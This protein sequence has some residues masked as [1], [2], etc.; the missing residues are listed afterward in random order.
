MK[1]NWFATWFDSNYYH[2]LYQHR[3]DAEA[4]FFIDNLIQYLDLPSQAEVLDLACGKG[5]HS[6]YL[7]QKNLVVQGV[8]LSPESI[9][10]AKQ[11]E[12]ANLSFQTHDMRQAIDFGKFDAIL[13]LFTSFGYFDTEEEHLQTLH[14]MKNGRKKQDDII[15]IDFFNAY[16]VIQNLVLE[17]TKTLNGITFQLT[18]RVENGAITKDIQF[19][20]AGQSYYFQESVQA[21]SL[22]NF[23]RLLGKVGLRIVETFGGY[24]LSSFDKKTSNR[25]IM[26]LR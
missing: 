25:L 3:N 26:L 14:S 9:A 17:E 13:N 18:R 15:V 6:I 8:D 2:I 7:A 23:E 21:F 12:K 4:H 5:R 22:E 20:D 24:D 1:K 11:F 16:K 10:H 19:E